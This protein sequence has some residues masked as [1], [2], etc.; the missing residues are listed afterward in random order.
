MA[1]FEAKIDDSANCE[2]AQVPVEEHS[3]RNEFRQ[4]LQHIQHIGIGDYWQ[5]N[6][7]F[8]LPV[9]E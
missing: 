5:V 8:Y 7:V 9:P 1:V 4:Y 3:R 2:R 6:E